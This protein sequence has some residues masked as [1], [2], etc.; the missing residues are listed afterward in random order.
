MRKVEKLAFF[1]IGEK[2]Y[3]DWIWMVATQVTYITFWVSLLE[4]L[5]KRRASYWRH[6]NNPLPEQ[7][8]Y[9]TKF[10]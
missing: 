3:L 8:K 2:N 7:M 1:G 4:K 5:K 10:W 6:G 9:N